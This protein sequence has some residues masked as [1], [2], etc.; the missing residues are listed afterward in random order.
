MSKYTEQSPVLFRVQYDA[1]PDGSIT[2]QAFFEIALVNDS[3]P[4]DVITKPRKSVTF[5]ITAEQA[6]TIEALARAALTS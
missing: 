5:T 3:D 1:A 2:A 6:A 4:S